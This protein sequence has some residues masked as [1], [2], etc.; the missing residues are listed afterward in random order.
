ML[1]NRTKG[2]QM[3]SS[4]HNL[5]RNIKNVYTFHPSHTSSILQAEM[6]YECLSALVSTLNTA[7]T[8]IS[9]SMVDII[10][11]TSFFSFVTFS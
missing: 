8:P 1:I 11:D 6:S 5:A 3:G 10:P 2:G 7:I 9:I 4:R